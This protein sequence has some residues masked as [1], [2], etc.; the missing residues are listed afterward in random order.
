MILMSADDNYKKTLCLI[1]DSTKPPPGIGIT[2]AHSSSRC[3]HFSLYASNVG[4]PFY[5]TF[6]VLSTVL[7]P[8]LPFTESPTTFS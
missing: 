2:F 5:I 1:Q 3:G 8:M 6:F 4:P 7:S